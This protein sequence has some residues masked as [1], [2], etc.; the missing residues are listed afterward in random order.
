ME[1]LLYTECKGTFTKRKEEAL[2]KQSGTAAQGDGP[3]PGGVR[4]GAAG[5][6]ADRQLHRE[7]E[8]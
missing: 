3:E 8:I 5:V 7:W 6:A 4:P 1:F 2:E